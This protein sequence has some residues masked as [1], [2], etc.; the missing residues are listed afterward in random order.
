[1]EGVVDVVGAA[2]VTVHRGVG[3]QDVVVGRQ[4]GE[5]QVGDRPARRR[6]PR[7]GRLRARFAGTPLQFPW[8]QCARWPCRSVV[9]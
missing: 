4:V 1:M 8:R 7:R 2:D 5:A 3:A 9:A 6:A